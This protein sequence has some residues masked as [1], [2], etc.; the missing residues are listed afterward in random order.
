M[1]EHADDGLLCSLRLR[2][3]HVSAGDMYL[4]TFAISSLHYLPQVL[5]GT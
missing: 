4:I 2:A 3:E 1:T 5:A